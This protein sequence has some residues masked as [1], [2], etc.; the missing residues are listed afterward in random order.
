M[1]FA[2]FF[3]IDSSINRLGKNWA[4]AHVNLYLFSKKL[5][6]LEVILDKHFLKAISLPRAY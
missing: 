2:N 1:L 5:C 3:T 6:V 4:N